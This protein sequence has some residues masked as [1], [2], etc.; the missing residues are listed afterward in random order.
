[1][2]TQVVVVV[3]LQRRRGRQDDVGVAGGLVQVGSSDTMN[4]AA[5][6]PRQLAAVGVDSTGLPAPAK[7]R[8][9]WPSPGW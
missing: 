9:I 6:G 4:S 7:Q 1:M 8:P 5:L 2:E 3:V